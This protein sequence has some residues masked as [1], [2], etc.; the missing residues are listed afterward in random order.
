MIRTRSVVSPKTPDMPL[1]SARPLLKVEIP[2][3]FQIQTPKRFPKSFVFGSGT[4]LYHSYILH[5]RETNG[6][7][8]L[9]GHVTEGWMPESEDARRECLR[10]L[11]PVLRCTYANRTTN[12]TWKRKCRNFSAKKSQ[13]HRFRKPHHTHKA[14]SLSLSFSL[15]LFHFFFCGRGGVLCHDS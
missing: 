15:S 4:V 12:E 1:S 8:E 9:E 11:N 13:H 3:H 5:T 14:V 2:R 7:N 6:T 10:L